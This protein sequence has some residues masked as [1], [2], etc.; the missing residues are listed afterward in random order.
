MRIGL[1]GGLANNMYVF[2]KAMATHGLDVCFI[3]DRGDRF[4]F[5]QPVWEDVSCTLDH[6][7]IAKAVHWTW[8]EWTAWEH[9]LEWQPPNWL[10]DPL[11][12][13]SALSGFTKNRLPLGFKA[14]LGILPF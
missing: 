10:K 14:D 13:I 2:A 12:A 3:R 4:P 1:Y 7:K 5:S 9:Q 6:D 8:E 11:K